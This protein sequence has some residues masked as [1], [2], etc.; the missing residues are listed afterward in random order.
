[1]PNLDSFCFDSKTFCCYFYFVS[2]SLHYN[3]KEATSGIVNDSDR[4]TVVLLNKG[5]LSSTTYNSLLY[6]V[7]S[8]VKIFSSYLLSLFD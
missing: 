2:S 6:F 3:P 8:S 7:L 1:M 5:S 4:K